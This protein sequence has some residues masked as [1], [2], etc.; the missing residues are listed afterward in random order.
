VS[1]RLLISEYERNSVSA[2][3]KQALIKTV[4]GEEQS[5]LSGMEA[6]VFQFDSEANEKVVLLSRIE[7]ALLIISL[8]VILAEIIF[9]FRPTAINVNITI[10]K[11]LQS[12]KDSKKC[13]MNPRLVYLTREII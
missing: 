1:A 11:L 13:P 3:K 5:F 10:N 4:L 12:E 8:L 7:Y 6:V 9:I 2:N